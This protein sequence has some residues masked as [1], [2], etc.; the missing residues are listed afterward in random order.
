[1]WSDGGDHPQSSQVVSFSSV[2]CMWVVFL[3]CSGRNGHKGHTF[4][5]L[6]IVE[7]FFLC[8]HHIDMYLDYQQQQQQ[9]TVHHPELFCFVFSR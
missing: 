3:L 6:Y 7:F 1:M 8:S 4:K 9:Q 5:T 2:V